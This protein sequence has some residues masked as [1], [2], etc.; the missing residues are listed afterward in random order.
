MSVPYYLLYS[1]DEA[2]KGARNIRGA[3]NRPTAIEMIPNTLLTRFRT[4]KIATP[5]QEGASDR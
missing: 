2:A 5:P 3:G 4:Y 1:M